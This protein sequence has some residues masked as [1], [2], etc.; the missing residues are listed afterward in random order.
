MSGGGFDKGAFADFWNDC[1]IASYR[2][3][4][5]GPLENRG[6]AS[7]PTLRLITVSAAS[8]MHKLLLER[9]DQNPT[10]GATRDQSNATRDAL[11]SSSRT[12]VP[13]I[14]SG[15]SNNSVG[16]APAD[17]T[18]ARSASSASAVSA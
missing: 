3:L 18:A 17:T 8:A 7:K 5:S 16:G 15:S 2:R 6:T 11:R 1:V 4:C 14:I 13:S 10:V 9:A 12:L